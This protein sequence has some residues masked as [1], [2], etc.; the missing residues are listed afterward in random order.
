MF[1]NRIRTG[2]PT[3]LAALLLGAAGLAGCATEDEDRIGVPP[4]TEGGIYE[5]GPGGMNEGA[6]PDRFEDEGLYEGEPTGEGPW[7]T[8]S[9]EET[10][11][12][13]SPY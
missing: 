5:P 6:Y 3:F 12:P 13:G 9:A 4:E 10:Q 2:M 1:I 8:T 11:P 7:G